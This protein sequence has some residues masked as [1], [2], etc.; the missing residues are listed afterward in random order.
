MCEWRIIFQA[1]YSCNKET[2]YSFCPL[3]TR[4]HLN[5]LRRNTV[6]AVSQEIDT[7]LVPSLNDINIGGTPSGCSSSFGDKF[8]D[9]RYY[10]N[11]VRG[12][13]IFHR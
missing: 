9:I 7:N 12:S 2:Y 1:I 6:D 13:L 5:N 4:A 3:D 8:P 10:P 11:T